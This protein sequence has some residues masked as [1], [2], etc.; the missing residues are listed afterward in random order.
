L[1]PG[2][3]TLEVTNPGKRGSEPT[4]NNANTISFVTLK[5]IRRLAD[6]ALQKG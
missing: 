5:A 6:T 3:F 1:G 4:G 2:R